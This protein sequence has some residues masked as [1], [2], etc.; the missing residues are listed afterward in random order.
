MT[1][2]LQFFAQRPEEGNPAMDPL[3]Q[4]QEDVLADILRSV[5]LHSTLYCR[6]QLGAPWGLGI[7][8]RE[9]AVF[10]IVTRGACWLTVA[11][12]DA[13]VSLRDG[14][15]VILP[16]G[17]AHTVTDHPDTQITGFEDFVSQHPPE[18]NGMVSSEGRGAVA[19]LVCGGFQLEDYPANPLYALLPTYLYVPSHQ[20]QGM[21]WIKAIVKLVRAE[22]H[23]SQPGAETV[24]TRLSE[25]LFIHAVRE[26]LRSVSDGQIGLLRALKN[27]EV[28]RTLMRIRLHPE[29]PWT[30]ESLAGQVGLSRS[31]FAAKFAELVGKP[32]MQYLTRVRLS[33]GA[34]LLRTQAA[35][36]AA[37]AVAVGY[38]SDVTFS[39][40]FK[41][42][43]GVTP[44]EYRRGQRGVDAERKAGEPQD[45]PVVGAA[46]ADALASDPGDH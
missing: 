45:E 44:G 34:L 35:S 20:R 26:Y 6:A 13:P 4:V 2:T 37:V 30:V 15:L 46:L 29:Q 16:H 41:R 10:H 24:I 25:V 5:H 43:F 22:A 1:D 14:D 17:H 18:P 36:L 23:G 8:R 42:C 9:V 19:T 32:P 31:A 3:T 28:G 11:G 33:K 38:E 12:L 7:P 21:P 39:K 27:P 40:A